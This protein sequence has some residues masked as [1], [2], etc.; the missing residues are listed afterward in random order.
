MIPQKGNTLH[1]NKRDCFGDI[2]E[3]LKNQG[4]V[5]IIYPIIFRREFLYDWIEIP[6]DTCISNCKQMTGKTEQKRHTWKEL[7][8]AFWEFCKSWDHFSASTSFWHTHKVLKI[9][10]VMICSSALSFQH[11]SCDDAGPH[12]I[13]IYVSKGISDSKRFRGYFISFL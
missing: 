8:W 5:K 12:I 11:R 2:W 6:D 7:E 13:V 3:C 10:F 9:L 4:L 1:E